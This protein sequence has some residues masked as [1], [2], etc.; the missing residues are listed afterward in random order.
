[1]NENLKGLI[2][3]AEQ[4]DIE[5]MAMVGDCYQK[6]FHVEKDDKISHRYYQKAADAGHAKAALMVAINYLNGIGVSKNMKLGAKYLQSAADK[7]MAYAQYL[8]AVLYHNRKIGLFF[9]EQ[10]AMKYYEM[11][12]RQGDAKSQIQLADL[13][14]KDKN[15]KYS[16]NDMIF[17]LVCAYLHRLNNES[18][19]ESNVALQRLNTL[20]ESGLPGG[21]ARIEET[22]NTVKKQY[23]TYLKNPF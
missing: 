1:M 23:P 10:K 17:W 7:G 9:C 8:L 5:A 12:A 20:I 13:I 14:W 22:I 4:G 6:G 21:K 19:E 11:A 18:M 15:S 2:A 3:K 16:L